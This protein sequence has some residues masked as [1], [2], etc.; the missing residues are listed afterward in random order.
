MSL[1]KFFKSITKGPKASGMG[2]FLGQSTGDKEAQR[3]KKDPLF[4]ISGK[5]GI[6]P[7][8][9]QSERLQSHSLLNA[10]VGRIKKGEAKDKDADA[11]AIS[12][13]QQAAAAAAAVAEEEPFLKAQESQRNALKRKGRR[14]S[15]LTSSQG[16]GD[17]LGIPG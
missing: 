2:H 12:T 13:E 5:R 15:I 7:Y 17:P 14:A 10:I 11:T 4:G 8:S 16:A 1:G 6:G 3:N 9:K